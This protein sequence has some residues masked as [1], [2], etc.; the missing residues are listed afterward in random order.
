MAKNTLDAILTNNLIVG[1][2]SSSLLDCEDNAVP[3]TPLGSFSHNDLFAQGGPLVSG[4]C[5]DPTGTSGNI[6]TNPLFEDALAADTPDFRLR[7]GSPAI[8]SG[9]NTAPGLLP[10]DLLGSPRI[11]Q[12]TQVSPPTIDMGSYEAAGI[13]GVLPPPPPVSPPPASPTFALTT[14]S[15][16]LT[17]RTEHHSSV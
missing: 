11:Q 3:T 8:D 10:T 6:S 7:V 15:S 9:L 16:L 2:S 13:P 14:S 4:S 12:A 17:I 5:S 1:A